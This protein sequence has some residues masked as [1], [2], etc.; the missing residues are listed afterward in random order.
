MTSLHCQTFEASQE[1]HGADDIKTTHFRAR[2][3]LWGFVVLNLILSY[4]L[5][6]AGVPNLIQIT[7]VSVVTEQRFSMLLVKMS[8]VEQLEVR[9]L[10]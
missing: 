1:L 9:S 3:I 5:E 7:L 4:L 8:Q 10:P 2:P 6:K